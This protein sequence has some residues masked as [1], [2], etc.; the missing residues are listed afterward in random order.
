MS[1]FFGKVIL[2]LSI[3]GFAW[4]QLN[5]PANSKIFGVNLEKI[6]KHCEYT[7]PL[8][9]VLQHSHQI[10]TGVCALMMFSL[11]MLFGQSKFFI[12][13]NILGVALYATVMTN[14]MLENDEAIKKSATINL[15]KLVSIIGGLI[16]LMGS[17]C[18]TET[19]SKGKKKG[20]KKE[21]NQ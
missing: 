3:A 4:L 7:K 9:Q 14:P 10:Y 17:D 5:N 13:V 12:F 21:K 18:G 16:F 1:K 15:L 11:F 2:A 19:C 6:S 8:E 20:G